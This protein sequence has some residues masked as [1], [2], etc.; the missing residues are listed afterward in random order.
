MKYH[1]LRE[2]M[3]FEFTDKRPEPENVERYWEIIELEERQI[4]GHVIQAIWMGNL[5][6]DQVFNAE[7][8]ELKQAHRWTYHE[9]AEVA[10]VKVKRLIFLDGRDAMDVMVYEEGPQPKKSKRTVIPIQPQKAPEPSVDEQ[11]AEY[12]EDNPV[13]DT[14]PTHFDLSRFAP[15]TI[16]E[17]ES[18][19][20]S[21]V[22]RFVNNGQVDLER[23]PPPK[24]SLSHYVHEQ[25]W[26][27]FIDGK[28]IREVRDLS[29]RISGEMG[30]KCTYETVIIRLIKAGHW[31]GTTKHRQFITQNVQRRNWKSQ[32]KND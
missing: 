13:D 20:D 8:K 12:L 4:R 21:V 11:I 28:N 18:L 14:D 15:Y 3:I 2:G 22:M 27:A 19:C 23:K 29:L 31:F 6:N 24:K 7:L 10:D 26:S 9:G 16:N 32:Q 1:H 17:W 25:E 30:K 5:G